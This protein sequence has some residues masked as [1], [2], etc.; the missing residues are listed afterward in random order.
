MMAC[1]SASSIGVYTTDVRVHIWKPLLEM[2]IKHCMWTACTHEYTLLQR[3]DDIIS[4]QETAVA[5]EI[6]L[7]Y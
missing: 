2:N 3:N 5:A 1:T 6:Y 4:I 7:S